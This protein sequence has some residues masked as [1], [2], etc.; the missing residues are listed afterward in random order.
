MRYEIREMESTRR[1]V[2]GRLL[3]ATNDLYDALDKLLILQKEDRNRTVALLTAKGDIHDGKEAGWG[4]GQNSSDH[5]TK[6]HGDGT[7]DR[8]G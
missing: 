3:Y 5:A 2:Y 6:G 4:N 7:D 8:Q 1:Q